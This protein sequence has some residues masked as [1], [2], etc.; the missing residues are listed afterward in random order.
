MQNLINL[1]GKEYPIKFGYGAIYAFEK[2]TGKSIL[3]VFNQ[4]EGG[5]VM[6]SDIIDLTHAGLVQGARSTGKK[7]NEDALTVA[8]WL[9]DAAPDTTQRI[10]QALADSMPK[11]AP[12]ENATD[13]EPNEAP[14]E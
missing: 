14:G 10:I 3:S 8:D 6:F 11:L 2:K 1:N 4:M 13:T 5:E 9:T 7:F 12:S